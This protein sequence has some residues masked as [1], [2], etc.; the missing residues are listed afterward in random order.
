MGGL[1]TLRTQ[2][3]TGCSRCEESLLSLLTGAKN[4]SS[5]HIMA[6]RQNWTPDS[7]PLWFLFLCT[8]IVSHLARATPVPQVVTAATVS[9][10]ITEDPAP[11]HPSTLPATKRCPALEVT[12]PEDGIS[13][14]GTLT[15]SCTACSR[16]H[17]F[18][19]LYWLGN[20]SFIEH[21]PDRLWEGSTSWERRG[22]STQLKKALV[23]E[24]LSPV[25]LNTNFSCVFT[26]P[27]YTVQRHVVLA[28]LLNLA[29]SKRDYGKSTTQKLKTKPDSGDTG[30]QK[31]TAYTAS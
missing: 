25:L 13:P 18:S 11:S 8:H 16:F 5:W 2:S 15:L 10:G 24:E 29:H 19:I 6:T 3:D 21:L 30:P 20:G 14:N 26:D 9:A 23:L 22:A 17:H 31:K 4:T 27:E 1:K 7:S 28:H 12:W